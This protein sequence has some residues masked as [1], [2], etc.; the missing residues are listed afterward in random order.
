M[1]EG[2]QVVHNCDVEGK[3]YVGCNIFF[4]NTTLKSVSPV[5]FGVWEIYSHTKFFTTCHVF[6]CRSGLW[7]GHSNTRMCFN[8]CLTLIYWRMSLHPS[9]GSICRIEQVF[10]HPPNNLFWAAKILGCQPHMQSLVGVLLYPS[11]IDIQFLQ[12]EVFKVFSAFTQTKSYKIIINDTVL[13][14]LC[15][16]L[17]S[18]FVRGGG[19]VEVDRFSVSGVIQMTFSTACNLTRNWVP[20]FSFPSESSLRRRGIIEDIRSVSWEIHSYAVFFLSLSLSALQIVAGDFLCRN[21][22]K[23]GEKLTF[24]KTPV[25]PG[26]TL[27][28]EF[29]VHFNRL[30][31]NLRV[32]K[33]ITCTH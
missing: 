14:L 15:F 25:I 3:W 16:S 4:T 9:F 1:M 23:C 27:T 10:L 30:R 22:S 2:N 28:S 31:L 33:F 26:L 21:Q 7:L 12:W 6:R 5:I 8:L 11:R 13:F 20:A 24:P 32:V 17:Q 29:K 18:L 19:V